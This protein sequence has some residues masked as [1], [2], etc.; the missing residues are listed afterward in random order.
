MMNRIFLYAT[1]MGS[2]KTYIADK[3]VGKGYTKLSLATPLKDY[4][5][6]FLTDT[7]IE[8]DVTSKDSLLSSGKSLR[9]YYIEIG[10]ESKSLYGQDHWVKL[11]LDKLEDNTKYVID[12]VRTPLEYNTLIEHGFTPVF[13]DALLLTPDNK[14]EG[15]LINDPVTHLLNP[16]LDR[17]DISSTIP[18]Y[19]PNYINE[20]DKV[21]E[22]LIDRL[23]TSTPI[24]YKTLVKFIEKG[25]DLMVDRYSLQEEVEIKLQFKQ[26]KEDGECGRVIIDGELFLIRNLNDVGKVCWTIN[27]LLTAKSN[28]TIL[29]E[30]EEVS[31]AVVELIKIDEEEAL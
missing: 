22:Y 12:D 7:G 21:V 24:P 8:Y 25:I 13:V 15:L 20:N 31:E 23:L 1:S 30:V 29:P 17:P 3:L 19:F 27:K 26:L 2:G 5:H 14:M 11:L 10:E 4:V 28:T 18:Y 6:T 9:D 16:N